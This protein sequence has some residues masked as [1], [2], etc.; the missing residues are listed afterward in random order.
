MAFRHIGRGNDKLLAETSL[1]RRIENS[2]AETA[3]AFLIFIPGIFQLYTGDGIVDIGN[4]AV[5][6]P[7]Y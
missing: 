7:G 4:S 3:A 6:S 2:S 5:C 1:G